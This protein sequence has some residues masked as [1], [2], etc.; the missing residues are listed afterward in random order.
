MDDWLA[1]SDDEP[2]ESSES[3]QHLER[4]FATL[5]FKEGVHV[6]EEA[7]LQGG[8]N[9]GFRTGSALGIDEGT[10]SGIIRCRIPA[11]ARTSDL[12]LTQSCLP[13]VLVA[14]PPARCRRCQNTTRAPGSH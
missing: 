1:D 4:R 9:R 5:G 12:P 11:T 2:S 10:L 3:W 13:H 7:T 6:G 14:E 8:F